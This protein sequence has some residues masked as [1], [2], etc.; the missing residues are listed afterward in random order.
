MKKIV[1]LVFIAFFSFEGFA[2]Q[3][4]DLTIATTGNN[5]LR[6][7]LNGR[8]ITLKDRSVTFENL[9]PGNYALVVYQLQR[10]N[11]GGNNYVEVF[12][13]SIRLIAGKQM[14]ITVLRFGKVVW[15][16][17][18]ISNDDWNDNNSIGGGSNQNGNDY[19]N[20]V[21]VT[22]E[23]F[24]SVKTQIEQSF[25]DGNKLVTAKA[26]MK[27]KLFKVQQIKELAVLFFSDSNRLEFLKNAYET[28]L[29]KHLYFSLGEAL[30]F[31][32]YK[33]DFMKWLGDR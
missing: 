31:N 3:K 2:Q 4:A 14:E 18:F 21:E 15:D 32:P 9:N 24:V 11:N 17:G 22:P 16:E 26:V 12:N 19:N 8:K 10:R 30:S 20:S 6:I 25:N 5:N 33:Q 23:M 1:L 28:C 27:N 7:K 13:N 29:E